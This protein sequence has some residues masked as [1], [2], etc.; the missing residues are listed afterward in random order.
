M[1]VEAIL[2]LG[3]GSAGCVHHRILPCFPASHFQ[4]CPPPPVRQE[5]FRCGGMDAWTLLLL[6]GPRGPVCVTQCPGLHRRTAMPLAGDLS[7]RSSLRRPS[8]RCAPLPAFLPQCAPSSP[9]TKCMARLRQSCEF[10]L[11]PALSH[12]THTP[13]LGQ[14]SNILQPHR[15]PG[16]VWS[17]LAWTKTC[18]MTS[19][20]GLAEEGTAGVL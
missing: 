9:P 17:R 6:A 20:P 16:G 3:E 13:I 2:R 10:H 12:L 19:K 1:N 18:S 14:G 7:H 4:V 5:R 8:L 15:P 11:S